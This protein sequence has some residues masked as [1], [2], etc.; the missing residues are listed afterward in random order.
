MAWQ[1]LTLTAM[2]LALVAYLATLYHLAHGRERLAV[3]MGAKI[4]LDALT[5]DG[6]IMGEAPVRAGRDEAINLEDDFGGEELAEEGNLPPII[7]TRNAKAA[8]QIGDRI[9]RDLMNTIEK[10]MKA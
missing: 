8:E 1:D 10:G 4:V 7:V 3:E 6:R 2:F 5:R 9:T